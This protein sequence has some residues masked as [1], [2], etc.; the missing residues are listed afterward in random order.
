MLTADKLIEGIVGDDCGEPEV[1]T[2]QVI[3]RAPYASYD[4]S[5]SPKSRNRTCKDKIWIFNLEFLANVM[6]HYTNSLV[7]ARREKIQ[8]EIL[9]EINENVVKQLHTYYENNMKVLEAKQ[10]S[11]GQAACRESINK[12]NA[13]MGADAQVWRQRL[14]KKDQEIKSKEQQIEKNER[15]IKNLKAEVDAK[16]LA[17]KAYQVMASNTAQIIRNQV[18]WV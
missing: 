11:S 12:L 2:M 6:R 9:K 8:A 14:A 10:I 7:N 1:V 5:K 13:E 18:N 3:N 16:N 17:I 4:R 15:E